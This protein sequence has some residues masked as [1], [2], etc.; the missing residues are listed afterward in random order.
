M[1]N[2]SGGALAFLQHEAAGGIVM[3][4]AALVAL[5]VSNSPLA[6]AYHDFL[7]MPVSIRIGRA[8][9]D[10][11]M[12]HWINDGLMAIFFCLVG[13]EIKRELL[14][15]ELATREQ[16]LLPVLAALGGMAAPAAIYVAINARNVPALDGWAIPTATDIA[17]AVTV[18]TLLGPRVPAALKVFL[19]A[20]AIIDDLGA[21]VI[22][23]LFYTEKLSLLA[24][25]LAG[26]GTAGL[27]ALNVAGVRR[28]TP[29]IVVGIFVWVC[30]LKSGIHATLAGVLVGLSAPLRVEETSEPPLER[31]EHQLHPWVAF[32]VLPLFGFANA[33]VPLLDLTWGDLASPVTLGVALGLVIGK[34]VGILSAC[35]LATRTSLCRLPVGTSWPQLAGA[36]VLAGIGFTM[37]LFIGILAFDDPALATPV[38]LGVISASMVAALAGYVI[39]A[40]SNSSAAP[41]IAPA[42]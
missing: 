6:G 33:G 3:M 35:W 24:L 4:L 22:I 40:R 2:K 37:S 18:L 13:L 1:A 31:L 11:T 26:L 15:G 17:F 21:I 8:G 5:V 9:L 42:R 27:L 32:L 12:I 10:K 41:D 38:R 29:Y 28:I 7:E 20:L 14:A 23:A 19:L 16:A 39:L 30:V 25:G 34:P 36:A